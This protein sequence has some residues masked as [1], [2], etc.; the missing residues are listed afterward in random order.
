MVLK[1][2][3]EDD[4][5]SIHIPDELSEEMLKKWWKWNKD[6]KKI[7]D[8]VWNMKDDIANKIENNNDEKKN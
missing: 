1:N 3:K 8:L 4:I 6:L 7:F 2:K 5:I